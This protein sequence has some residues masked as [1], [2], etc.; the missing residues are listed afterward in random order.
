VSPSNEVSQDASQQARASATEIAQIF[1]NPSN[2]FPH[3][4]PLVPFCLFIAL[5]YLLLS[6]KESN[7]VSILRR[8]LTQLGLHMPA[9]GTPI[10]IS[11]LILEQ[12]CVALE[13]PQNPAALLEPPFAALY[14]QSH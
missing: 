3:T 11:K 5:R 2:L 10:H 13:K 12:F 8:A 14:Q 9:A 1:A 6:N 7:N 4:S